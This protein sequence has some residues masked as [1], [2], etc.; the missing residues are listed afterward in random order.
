MEAAGGRVR[1]RIGLRFFPFVILTWTTAQALSPGARVSTAEKVAWFASNSVTLRSINPK[2][3]D[4]SDLRPVQQAIGN[5]RVVLLGGGS[6]GAT[7]SARCRLVRFLHEEMGF[8]VLTS[9]LPLFDAE[10]F[11]RPLDH[12]KAPRPDLEV[13]NARHFGSYGPSY[14]GFNVLEYARGTHKTDRPLHIAGFGRA[15]SSYMASEYPKRLFQFVDGIDSRMASPAVRKALQALA[16]DCSPVR[17]VSGGMGLRMFQLG[18]RQWEKTLSPG[19]AAIRILTENLG[20]VLAEGPKMSEIVFYRQTLANLAYYAAG[21]AQRPL[22]PR[23]VDS[24]VLLAEVWRPE[25]KIIVWS[26]NWTVGRNWSPLKRSN[27]DPSFVARTTGNELARV[28]GPDAYAIAF[29]AIKNENGVLQVLEAGSGP[30]LAPVDGDLDSLL[31]AAG[32]P[33]SFVDFRSVPQDHWLRTP[34]SARLVNGAD[35]SVWPDHFDGIVTVDVPVWK[36]RK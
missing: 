33:F 13:M 30:K 29:S 18:S 26:G 24:A 31:H 7:V 28:L 8:D 17:N 25:S 14:T 5:A 15:V 34:L 23:P 22:A 9:E 3:R 20:Q 4:F 12:G 11:D 21:L 35:V 10:E 19:L 27:G 1:F 6:D 36:A 16:A 2:D 32:K